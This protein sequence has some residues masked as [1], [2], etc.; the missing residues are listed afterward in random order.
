MCWVKRVRSRVRKKRCK[1]THPH[2]NRFAF[3]PFYWPSLRGGAYYRRILIARAYPHYRVISPGAL[4]LEGS[5]S[6]PLSVPPAPPFVIPCTN[7][8]LLFFLTLFFISV[9]LFGIP[10][11]VC[12]CCVTLHL[13]RCN[14]YKVSWLGRGTLA[15]S[16]WGA[17][18]ADMRLLPFFIYIFLLLCICIHWV[19]AVFSCWVVEEWASC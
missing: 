14:A 2:C 15:L 4:G 5:C 11:L 8:L 10:T 6:F 9:L 7:L 17:D 18:H 13:P 1:K 16:D 3:R 12:T 19:V